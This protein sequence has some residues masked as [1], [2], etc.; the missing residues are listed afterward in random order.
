MTPVEEMRALREEVALLRS[1]IAVLRV[2]LVQARIPAPA[3]PAPT[4]PPWAPWPVIYG[5][6][7]ICQTSQTIKDDG[8]I[9]VW[10]RHDS[11]EIALISADLRASATS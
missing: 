4:G 10:N 1:E 8:T 6:P 3:A 7:N 11:G 5:S 9:T 2:E